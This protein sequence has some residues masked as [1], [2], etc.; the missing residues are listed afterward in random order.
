MKAETI[1][2]ATRRR[3]WPWVTVALAAVAATAKCR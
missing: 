3:K 1:D 2:E